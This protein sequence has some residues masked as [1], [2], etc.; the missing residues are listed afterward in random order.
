VRDVANLQADSA[1]ADSQFSRRQATQN[2]GPAF[3][4]KALRLGG[5]GRWK[6]RSRWTLA[7]E[8]SAVGNATEYIQHGSIGRVLLYLSYDPFTEPSLGSRKCN[9]TRGVAFS[10]LANPITLGQ[11]LMKR[12]LE[13]RKSRVR[14]AQEMGVSLKTL[15]D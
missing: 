7:I 3:A 9:E 13:T 15:T 14:C 2:F 10:S 5:W 11:K 6:W 4:Q 1:R 8:R 12:R